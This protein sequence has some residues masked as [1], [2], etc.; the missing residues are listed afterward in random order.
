[1]RKSRFLKHFKASVLSFCVICFALLYPAL[2]SEAAKL[3]RYVVTDCIAPVFE[4]LKQAKNAP[5]GGWKTIPEDLDYSSAVVYGDTAEGV[6][7]SKKGWVLLKNGDDDLGFIQEGA[8]TPFPVYDSMEPAPFQVVKETVIPCVLPGKKPVSGFSKF[9]LPYGAVVTVEGST[10]IKEK[11]KEK[12]WLLCFFGSDYDASVKDADYTTGSDRRAGWVPAETVLDLA[13]SVP[14]LSKVEENKLPKKLDGAE[15][16]AI[17]KNGFYVNPKPVLHEFMNNDDMVDAYSN[18]PPLT[19]KIITSDFPLHAFHLYFDR[20]LQKVE[21]KV[22]IGRSGELLTAMNG[23]FKKLRPELEGTDSGKKVA[24]LVNDWL[25]IA[26]HLVTGGGTELT[27]DAAGFAAMINEGTGSALSPFTGIIQDFTLFKPRGHYTLN[28]SLKAYF[29]VS[30]MLGTPF[31]LDTNTGAAASLV[32]CRILAEPDVEAKWKNL[33]DPICYMV[34]SSNV[35]SYYDL[36]GVTAQFKLSDIGDN[37]KIEEIKAALDK[38]ARESVIQRLPGKKFAVLPR[39]VTFDAMIFETLTGLKDST[40]NKRALPDPL[41]VMAV[42][43]SPAAREEV[44]KYEHFN[45]YSEKLAELG[46]MW[47][48]YRAGGYGD[49]VYTSWLAFAEIYFEPTLSGQ[50][51]AHSPAWG[52]KKLITAEASV[53]ELKHDTIL[54]AEQSGAEMGEGGDLGAAPFKLPIARGYVEPEAKLYRAMAETSGKIIKFLKEMFPDDENEYYT[55]NLSEFADTMNTLAGMSDRAVADSM[56]YDDFL[57]IRDFKLP[58]VMPE[59]ISDVFEEEAQK[60]LRMALVADVA[61]DPDTGDVLYMGTGVPRKISVYVNDRSGGFRLTEGYVFSYYSFT[62]S[63]S[64]GRIDDDQWKSMV[65]D[66][67]KQGALKL[68][69]PDWSEKVNQ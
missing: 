36:S 19:P 62:Q 46:K 44:K 11:D 12:T 38:A 58:S 51:F 16:K 56:T 14:D 59:G 30:Y 69:L 32:L 7:S 33:F 67:E 17:L 49:N 68:R 5:K 64:E 26:T 66:P 28:D 3:T 50:F 29:K 1:M 31:P 39:R 63:N 60:Q 41:D 54:Y 53:T 2:P 15:H 8:L 10:K 48:E 9:S 47:P 21:E 25:M 20:M 27:G 13:A 37:A 40:D 35:N 65:Y 6:P 43:G 23:A 52:Y 45:G 61:T 34:G 24:A 22:L 4:T 42:L 55:V 57:M 18:I